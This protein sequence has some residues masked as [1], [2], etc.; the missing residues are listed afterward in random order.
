MLIYP[1]FGSS[2]YLLL[3]LSLVAVSGG[4]SLL[5]CEGLS[6]QWLLL[7]LST[8]SRASGCGSQS[9]EHRFCSC[10][11]RRLAALWP[12]GS[13][14][15]RNWTHVPALADRFL[16]TE[17]P[18][19]PANQCSLNTYCVSVLLQTVLHVCV[20]HAHELLA[21]SILVA[22]LVSLSSYFLCRK[23]PSVVSDRSLWR[24]DSICMMGWA[25]EMHC[26]V[27]EMAFQ[28]I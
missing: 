24:M 11:S 27:Q 12:L 5:R 1:S 15:A 28:H 25:G 8:G 14:W 23:K 21:S 18:E 10:G 26:R 4:C 7:C 6:L 2:E 19:K 13:S 16:T 22:V 17:P 20:V 3:L 9:P